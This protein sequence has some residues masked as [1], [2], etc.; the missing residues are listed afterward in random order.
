LTTPPEK[1]PSPN[2]V[3]R[4]YL[5][6]IERSRPMAKVIELSRDSFGKYMS[7]GSC[8]EA[9]PE[10]GLPVKQRGLKRRT[11]NKKE[12]KPSQS[13]STDPEK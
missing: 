2:N 6:S 12:A 7:S 4:K 13:S 3:V 9:E 8:N 11:N 1:S 10:R 5:R